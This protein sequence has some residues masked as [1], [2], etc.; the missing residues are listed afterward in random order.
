MT[1]M[2]L[3]L[4]YCRT[5]GGSRYSEAC[6]SWALPNHPGVQSGALDTIHPRSGQKNL[7][8]SCCTNRTWLAATGIVADAPPDDGDGLSASSSSGTDSASSNDVSVAI[9]I[10][11]GVMIVLY[12][13]LE[14]TRRYSR[15]ESTEIEQGSTTL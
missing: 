1:G 4:L 2:R 10:T 5:Y 14:I 8:G 13:T 7:G 12:G 11:L 6:A 9:A 3:G 15:T